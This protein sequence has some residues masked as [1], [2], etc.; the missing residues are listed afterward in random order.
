MT[1]VELISTKL[2]EILGAKY[3]VKPYS[4]FAQD[5]IKPMTTPYGTAYDINYQAFEQMQNIIPVCVNLQETSPINSDFF[6]RTGIM[7][8]QF[9]VPVDALGRGDNKEFDFFGDYERL[10]AKLTDGRISL[11]TFKTD[12]SVLPGQEEVDKIY[13]SY[14]TLTE[15]STDGA[16]QSTGAY[17]R[18]VYTVQGNV[19][20]LENGLRTGDDYSIEIFDGT[21]YVPFNNITNVTIARDEQG[22]AVQNEGTTNAM[23]PPVS[24]VHSISFVVSDKDDDVAIA[25]LRNAVFKMHEKYVPYNAQLADTEA[26]QREMRI[27]IKDSESVLAEFWALLTASYNVG[28]K[29]SVGSFSVSLTRTDDTVQSVR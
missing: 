12:G 14:F 15:P 6:Y 20:V 3:E 2:Q 4:F 16:V 7:T 5:Y 25:I 27:R 9:Y 28:G 29:T 24:R 23:S 19:T 11:I 18:M 26:K 1:T 17:R 22:N 13:K 10:R 8:L 21:K